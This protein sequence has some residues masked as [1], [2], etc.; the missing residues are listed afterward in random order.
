MKALRRNIAWSSASSCPGPHRDNLDL[1]N[2]DY[3][4][5]VHGIEVAPV[6]PPG[7][8]AGHR[9]NLEGLPGV[10]TRDP[11]FGA[12]R[13]G[14]RS[15][16]P[17]GRRRRV[18]VVDRSAVVTTHLA[19]VVR[20][21]AGEL[22]SR[23]DTKLLLDSVKAANPVVL[24]EMTA[25]GLTLGDVQGVL[26]GL[27]EEGVPVRD[28]V[29]IVEALTEQARG[30]QKDAD[31]L[32]EAA[33]LALASTIGSMHEKTARCRPSR[34]PRYSSRACSDRYG[35]ESGAGGASGF[36]PARPRRSCGTS[37]ASCARPKPKEPAR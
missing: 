17:P 14:S 1:P 12:G 25:A 26:R 2:A 11:A 30:Q 19:E 9:E 4:V 6:R 18:T 21:H 35:Q 20:E 8:I 36:R 15:A 24:E 16:K 29:R 28:L 7:Q 5:K 31:S 32:F 37:G 13:S 34:S 33:R 3:T 22:I 23:Q 10:D 27:L